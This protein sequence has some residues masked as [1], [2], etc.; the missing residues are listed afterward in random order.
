MLRSSGRILL[1]VKRCFM[2]KDFLFSFFEKELFTWGKGAEEIKNKSI[3]EDFL[4][5]P[6]VRNPPA[7]AGDMGLIPGLGRSHMVWRN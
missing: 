2:G 5:G 3:C 7:N 4:D 1:D 6:V